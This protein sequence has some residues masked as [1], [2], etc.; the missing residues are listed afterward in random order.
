[1]D[2]EDLY[3]YL[4]G[5]SELSLF[6]EKITLGHQNFECRYVFNPGNIKDGI[7][8][9]I[10][11]AISSVVPPDSID[12]LVPG[13]YR[14]KI[15]FLI[16]GL[17]KE[18]RKQL[19]PVSDTVD[20]IIKEMSK[21]KGGLLTSLSNFIVE[22]FNIDIP[23]SEWPDNDLP[24]YLKMR[25]AITDTD[26]KT[27]ACSRDRGIL[28][29]EVKMDSNLEEFQAE[30]Q[31]W[32]KESITSW[33][34]PDLPE[35]IKLTGKLGNIQA[36]YPGLEK[37]G[38]AINLRLF[39]NM[40]KAV[41]SHK[42]GIK[43]LF[44]IYFA[45]DL[46]FLKK[47]LSVFK[48]DIKMASRFGDA[49]QIQ[50]QMFNKITNDLFLQNIRTKNEFL[51]CI[52][53]ITPLLLLQG[54]EMSEKVSAVISAFH[55]TRSELFRRIAVNRSKNLSCFFNAL[56]NELENLV[57]DSFI[58]IY[59]TERLDALPRYLKAIELRIQRALN[60]FEKDREKTIEIEKFINSL[61]E[62]LAGLSAEDSEE[63]RREI[64]NFF[65][66]I[67]E[68]KVSIFAQELKTPFPVSSKKL[69]KKLNEIKRIQ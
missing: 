21:K 49:E 38:M 58:T 66:L 53:S 13:L 52:E 57:P 39:L 42:D 19:V 25:I 34:F 1:M 15:M 31:K 60:N 35:S 50:Q 56:I 51:S 63:K 41:R 11:S 37:K 65:W 55:N 2:K 9:K 26:G 59:E 24:D 14:E 48:N 6:P 36:F 47:N 33:N 40:E 16:R 43:A 8:V 10:P 20:T 17:P 62:L 3:K 30:K 28:R 12:W 27:I 67:Q 18:Y 29:R 46:K 22:R 69:E 45:K 68:Y 44:M 32:E 4:P 7:T 54:K 23:V 61:N 5:E 64:E